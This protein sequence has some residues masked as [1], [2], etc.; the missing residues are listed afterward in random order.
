MG[1]GHIAWHAEAGMLVQF[2]VGDDPVV[3]A[4]AGGTVCQEPVGG[5][6]A[7]ESFYW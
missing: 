5:M 1:L 7:D 3:G 4:E 6:I 2:L